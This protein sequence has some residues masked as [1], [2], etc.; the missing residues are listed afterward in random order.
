MTRLGVGSIWSGYPCI[1]PALSGGGVPQVRVLAREPVL[2][3]WR[4]DVVGHQGFHGFRSVHNVARDEDHLAGAHIDGPALEVEPP[5]PAEHP[6]GLLVLVGVRRYH[7]S[8]VNLR[9]GD[10]QLA[11]PRE[12]AP[13]VLVDAFIGNVVPADVLHVR[14]S[15]SIR[16]LLITTFFFAAGVYEERSCES[17]EWMTGVCG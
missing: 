6:R 1:R 12:L 3:W 13:E 16:L 17:R 15:M 11:V 14:R 5:L 10:H 7:V 8:L 9:E 2:P 4:E